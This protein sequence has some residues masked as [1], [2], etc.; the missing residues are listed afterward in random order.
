MSVTMMYNTSLCTQGF[1]QTRTFHTGTQ[2]PVTR[3]LML[4]TNID[5]VYKCFTEC[6]GGSLSQKQVVFCSGT[7]VVTWQLWKFNSRRLTGVSSQHKTQKAGWGPGGA[8][9]LTAALCCP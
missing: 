7:S 1:T 4:S 8:G 2:E 3:F 5:N 6:R 9:F